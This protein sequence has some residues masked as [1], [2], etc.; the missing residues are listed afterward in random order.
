MQSKVIWHV[1]KTKARGMKLTHLVITAKD[2]TASFELRNAAGKLVA[3]SESYAR[4]WAAD[5]AAK[6]VLGSL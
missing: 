6:R 5:R 4:P 2:G 1:S 3:T